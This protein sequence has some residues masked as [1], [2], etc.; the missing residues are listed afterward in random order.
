[1][2]CPYCKAEIRMYI[3]N[4]PV[5]VDRGYGLDGECWDEYRCECPECGEKFRAFEDYIYTG[6]SS[7]KM[8]D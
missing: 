6:Q 2:N 4:D 5:F 7:M 3:D 1:M 8:E